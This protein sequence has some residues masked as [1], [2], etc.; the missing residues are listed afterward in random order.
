MTS[1]EPEGVVILDGGDSC[2]RLDLVEEGSGV[3]QAVVWPGV[4]AAKRS[5]HRF[6]LRAGART[7]LQKHASE[8][9]YY[10]V[11]GGGAVA[12]D[13]S[14]S[15]VLEAGAMIHVEP[16]TPYVLSAGS[17][18]LEMVGGPCPPDPGLYEQ[19]PG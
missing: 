15:Q 4:G 12:G 5:L 16:G 3:V 6:R 19:L 14:P 2:P 11:H 7:R 8:A 9:V 17:T 13:G 1:G 18:G 10:V